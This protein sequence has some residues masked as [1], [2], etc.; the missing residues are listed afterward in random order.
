MFNIL[1]TIENWLKGLLISTIK[2]ILANLFTIFDDNIKEVA[3]V[4]GQTPQSFNAEVFG[5][6]KTLSELVI[7]PIAGIITTFVLCYELIQMILEKNNMHDFDTF[8]IF[9]WI[10][11]SF[12]AVYIVTNTFTII[13]AIFEI[14]QD[15]VVQIGGYIG[16]EALN[17]DSLLADL[18]T[19]LADLEL[20]ELAILVFETF[21][22]WITIWTVA[23][24]VFIIAYG[25]MIK[26]YVYCSIGSIPFATMANKEWGGMGQNYL[27][28]LI[29]LAFEGFFIMICIAIYT[30]LISQIV[31]ESNI[32]IAI[33][34]CV[35]YS[36][37]LCFT[38]FQVGTISKSIFNS[39]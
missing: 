7:V 31:T 18:D 4:V 35:G 23:I 25:R 22:A 10:F 34:N 19:T 38:L 26:I 11:K 24:C 6:I 39:H 16:D 3:N 36:I 5:M 1:E 17:I 21:I 8:T 2:S 30:V 29:A 15:A 33:W 12:I 14:G 27:K 37:L 20:S 28:G 13:M 32:H 9:K